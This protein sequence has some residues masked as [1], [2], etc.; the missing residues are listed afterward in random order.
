MEEDHIKLQFRRLKRH[1]EACKKEV[2]EISLLD[3]AHTLRIWVEMAPSVDAIIAEREFTSKFPNPQK[4]KTISKIL[5]DADYLSVPLASTPETGAGVQ[6][7]DIIYAKKYLSPEEVKRMYE[8]GPT[9][10]KETDLS[11]QN[12]LGSEILEKRVGKG[13]DRERIGIPRCILIK[14]VANILGA[15]HPKGKEKAEEIER[16]FDPM[17]MEL[18][19]MEVANGY[20]LTYFQ[21]IEIAEIIIKTFDELLE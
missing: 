2:D 8:A 15:S 21:L 17:I 12:W 20:P 10:A 7:K 9:I 5:Q 16:H 13:D 18:N 1:Y 14:R 4:N 3:L 11:L 6:I 19:K